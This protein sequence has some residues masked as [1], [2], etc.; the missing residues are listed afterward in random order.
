MAKN[1]FSAKPGKINPPVSSVNGPILKMKPISKPFEALTYK[2]GLFTD[3]N[4]M[5]TDLICGS[6]K[7]LVLLLT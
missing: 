6:R 3:K 4:R 2:S 7:T 5:F 1:V